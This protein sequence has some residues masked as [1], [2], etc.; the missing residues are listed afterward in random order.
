VIRLTQLGLPA[1]SLMAQFESDYFL[2]EYCA[3]APHAVEAMARTFTD[4]NYRRDA[5]LALVV[6]NRDFARGTF[7]EA[8]IIG[9]LAKTHRLV[10]AEAKTATEFLAAARTARARH[11]QIDVVVCVGHGTGTAASC[12]GIE[13]SPAFE[14]LGTMLTPGAT[15]MLASCSGAAYFPDFLADRLA[16][17]R[18]RAVHVAAAMQAAMPAARVVAANDLIQKSMITFDATATTPEGRYRIAYT[19]SGV[20]GDVPGRA[21]NGTPRDWLRREFGPGQDWAVLETIDSDGDGDPNWLEYRAGT[22]PRSA[23]DV[24][25]VQIEPQP[26]SGAAALRWAGTFRNGSNEPFRVLFTPSGGSP[27]VV[28]DRVERTVRGMN[29]WADTTH[30]GPGTYSIEGFSASG[31]AWNPPLPIVTLTAD[32]GST[33]ADGVTSDGRVSVGNL[34]G[35]AW[36]YSRDGG[37]NWITGGGT[38]FTLPAATYAAGSVQV[39]TKA[40]GVPG[41]V[42]SNAAAWTIDRTPPAAPARRLG[43]GVASGATLAE[44]T[45]ASGVVTVTGEAGAAIR[46]TF[47]R[48]SVVVT[49]TLTG[50]GN[51]QA[52]VLA[53]GDVS[54]L[55]NGTVAVSATQTDLAGNPQTA[56]PGTASFT[57]DTFAPTVLSVTSPLAAGTY[58]IGQT[59]TVRVKFGEPV[60]VGGTPQLML[61]TTP[62]RVATYSSGSGTN[63]L[64]FSYAIQV[65][66]AAP[67]LDYASTT[68]LGLVGTVSA[69][70]RDAAG[71]DAIPAL[72]APGSPGSLG[73]GKVLVV[74]GIL[75]AT[76]AGFATTAPGPG[77]RLAVTRIPLIPLTFN[78]PVTGVTLAS[79]RLFRGDS[80]V[81]FGNASIMGSGRNWTLALPSSTTS[82]RGIY[83]LEIG[84]VGS[85][86]KSGAVAMDTVSTIFWRRL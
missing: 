58:G 47:S 80:L 49:K 62:A 45:Q 23:Q 77:F 3:V 61:N 48:G 56:T 54:A 16:G 30:R 52:V 15:V 12:F 64:V 71:N 24:L 4:P 74:A 41:P 82:P 27:Q 83:R 34:G 57:I 14:E 26:G 10:V 35:A 66:D 1:A 51:P 2:R 37:V 22:N 36:Q 69:T 43:T 33:G 60:F 40:S 25:R 5:P 55:G 39:R 53:A 46:V 84:G 76:A 70:I 7:S 42:G 68:A 73:G 18:S 28:A 63:T 50:T 75:R 31:A 85:G 17:N 6:V 81:S 79:V 86:I 44:A 72:P 13:D 8:D 21:A 19:G 11:G 78:A 65:G 20:W 38:S 9:T 59:V 32:T 67:R 29:A